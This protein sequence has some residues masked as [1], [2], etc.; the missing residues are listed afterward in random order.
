MTAIDKRSSQEKRRTRWEMIYGLVGVATLL[1]LCT[2][3][4]PHLSAGDRYVLRLCT[5][6]LAFTAATLIRMMRP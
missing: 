2:S 6:T 3:D 5:M 4:P 1:M